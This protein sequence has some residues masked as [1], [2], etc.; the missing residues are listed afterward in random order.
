MG[1]GTGRPACQ[2]RGVRPRCGY[3]LLELVIVV[4]ITGLAMAIAIPRGRR[5]LD[6]LAVRSAA[7]DVLATLGYARSIALSGGA[8]VAVHVDSTTGT[9]RVRQGTTVLLSRGIAHA[10]GV[11]V[12][13][14]RDSMVYDPRGLGRGAANLSLVVRRGAARETVFVSR[15]GRVR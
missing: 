11:R 6:R 7:G 10:H 9:I 13:A 12:T 8:R 5:L 14:T 2:R 4:T 15:L 3:S 1:A